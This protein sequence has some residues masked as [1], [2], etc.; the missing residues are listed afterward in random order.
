MSS[1]IKTEALLAPSPLASAWAAHLPKGPIEFALEDPI[2]ILNK[3]EQKKVHWCRVGR[4]SYAAYEAAQE[5]YAFQNPAG[6]S[7]GK[8]AGGVY[9]TLIQQFAWFREGNPHPVEG[10]TQETYMARQKT[11]AD[12]AAAGGWFQASQNEIDALDFSALTNL[13]E[14]LK[15]ANSL[16]RILI[17]AQSLEE[18]SLK[19]GDGFYGVTSLDWS[20]LPFSIG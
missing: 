8:D 14:I 17:P 3:G 18:V 15:K 7:L 2:W 11:E 12:A 9:K 16:G 19:K 5:K 4:F 6:E 10:E 13:K 20:R 1:I